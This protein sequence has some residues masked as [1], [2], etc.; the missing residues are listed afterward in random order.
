ML[1][2]SSPARV[3]VILAA[4]TGA[5]HDPLASYKRVGAPAVGAHVRM[6]SLL[7]G[8]PQG[9]CG[10][11]AAVTR[12]VSERF[13]W[14]LPGYDQRKKSRYSRGRAA[15]ISRCSA[16]DAHTKRTQS[17]H[18]A[19]TKKQPL[20]AGSRWRAGAQAARRGLVDAH[21]HLRCRWPRRWHEVVGACQKGVLQIAP[22]CFDGV[23]NAGDRVSFV[24]HEENRPP[25]YLSPVRFGPRLFSG[26]GHRRS[27]APT[28]RSKTSWPDGRR[29]A[30]R[31]DRGGRE[32]L[33]S[34]LDLRHEQERSPAV[35][36]PDVGLV[37][38]AAGNAK[39]SRI[40]RDHLPI[41]HV[42]SIRRPNCGMQLPGVEHSE[43][44]RGGGRRGSASA[45]L[46]RR[47]EPV[48]ADQRKSP[49][50]APFVE[51][52]LG[53]VDVPLRS[54]SGGNVQ[55]LLSGR[56]HGVRYRIADARSHAGEK[57]DGDAAQWITLHLRHGRRSRFFFLGDGALITSS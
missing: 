43:H 56:L 5:W 18:K 51:V 12:A 10:A 19:L 11:S 16:E 36:V 50:P 38:P 1:I 44:R 9:R 24:D 7:G 49:D 30:M 33:R 6:E 2:R 57:V 20:A 40:G 25:A 53:P 54:G 45:Q 13:Q 46:C 35:R 48:R 52:R 31:L 14:L 32:A 4:L 26:A 28:R 21:S 55:D 47:H 41:L 8:Q 39:A 42:L 15:G 22:G 17:A 34:R 23:L 3:F 29:A 27:P 37:Q